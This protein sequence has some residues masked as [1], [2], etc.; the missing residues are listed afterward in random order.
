MSSGTAASFTGV[1]PRT[2]ALAS[3]LL[4]VIAAAPAAAHTGGDAG[5]LAGGLGHAFRG[6]DHLLA[7]VVVGA[8][9]LRLRRW[10]LPALF[11]ALVAAGSAAGMQGIS[12]PNIEVLVVASAALLAASLWRDR[13]TVALVATAAFVHGLAHG[14]EAPASGGARYLAGFLMG[15]ALLHSIGILLI[16]A[17]R[18][19]GAPVHRRSVPPVA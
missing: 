13:T 4:A 10:H 3:I 14:A 8:A 16:L 18:R 5:T 2:V 19:V 7:M 15:A 6:I 9:S 12:V 11:I 17:W 1:K